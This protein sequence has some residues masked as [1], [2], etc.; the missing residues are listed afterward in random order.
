MPWLEHLADQHI[1]KNLP[2]ARDQLQ[3]DILRFAELLPDMPLAGNIQFKFF[4]AFPYVEKEEHQMN[5]LTGPDFKD[6][7]TLNEKLNLQK[8]EEYPESVGQI[9]KS[10]VGRYVGLHSVIPLKN[11]VE[12]FKEENKILKK[13]VDK[14]ERAFGQTYIEEDAVSNHNNLRE[15]LEKTEI[16]KKISDAIRKE[17]YRNKKFKE[18]FINYP[19]NSDGELDIEHTEPNEK[20]PFR[21]GKSFLVMGKQ[22]IQILIQHLDAKLE[23]QGFGKILEKIKEDK[24]EIFDLKEEEIQTKQNKPLIKRTFLDNNKLLYTYFDC[25][26]CKMKD[27]LME[28]GLPRNQ[29]GKIILTDE[30]D[31]RRALEFG[32][33]HHRGFREAFKRLRSW[34]EFEDMEET[35]CKYNIC[36]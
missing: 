15:E 31:V 17:N 11:E 2:K 33:F 21:R 4:P 13:S 9:F 20:Y 32:D 24:V 5:I 16:S 23:H 22:Q 10:I 26:Q 18:H 36:T 1:G 12:A 14:V 6:V 7:E 19:V 35:V 30:D 27:H 3:R 29:L 8:T 28:K 25:Q 34:C